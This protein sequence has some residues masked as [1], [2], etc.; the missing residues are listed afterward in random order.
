MKKNKYLIC[1]T[2]EG[3]IKDVSDLTSD[4]SKYDNYIPS[5]RIEQEDDTQGMSGEYDLVFAGAAD[6]TD[7]YIQNISEIQSEEKSS[8]PVAIY[9]RPDLDKFRDKQEEFEVNDFVYGYDAGMNRWLPYTIVSINDNGVYSLQ[10]YQLGPD[11]S[12]DIIEYDTD[13][14]D[15]ELRKQPVGKVFLVQDY[16]YASGGRMFEDYVKEQSE[17]VKDVYVDRMSGTVDI[18]WNDPT[19]NGFTTQA[20]PFW[21]EPEEIPVQVSIKN[22][23][24]IDNN[25]ND[26][27]VLFEATPEFFIGNNIYPNE[28]TDFYQAYVD[29]LPEI[30][31]IS[32]LIVEEYE[33]EQGPSS[34]YAEGG[35]VMSIDRLAQKLKRAYPDIRMRENEDS[36]SV[37]EDFPTDRRGDSIADYYSESE[38]RVFGMA[39][40]FDNFLK[41]NGYWAEWVNPE[42]F[43][44]YKLNTY[45]KGGEIEDMDY[46]ELME[47]VFEE[48]SSNQ[49]EKLAKEIAKIQGFKY[50]AVEYADFHLVVRDYLDKSTNK[51]DDKSREVLLQAFENTRISYG[52]GGVLTFKTTKEADKY[53]QGLSDEDFKK[54]GDFALV[55]NGKEYVIKKNFKSVG[56][57]KG[58]EITIEGSPYKNE[59]FF[60]YRNGKEVASWNVDEMEED[61]DVEDL[62]KEMYDLYKKDKKELGKRLDRISYAKGGKISTD[63]KALITGGLAGI[64]LGIFLNK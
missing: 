19:M 9:D 17:L 48:N 42:H 26:T 58:G 53:L 43:K 64:L 28:P 10:D 14:V 20:T 32:K 41:R 55:Y 63:N 60:I 46:E 25:I 54:L 23:D 40:H 24:P 8:V 1:Y 16:L 6:A 15:T 59:D 3:T 2:F 7:K 12:G 44:I 5:I 33:N 61:D 50:D 4:L 49:N 51:N 57:A 21:E 37:F 11:Q 56:Y 22:G 31:N 52:K 47:V 18:Y 35:R 62:A 29:V 34:T 30:L 36:I 45:A 38:D 27:N 13:D 39:N